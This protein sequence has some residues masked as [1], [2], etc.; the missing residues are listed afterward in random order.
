MKRVKR[1][2]AKCKKELLIAALRE[3]CPHGDPRFYELII[4]FCELHNDKNADYAS[5]QE[6]LGNFTRNGQIARM[7]GLI[8]P[9]H[10]ATKIAILYMQKQID[11]AYKLIGSGQKGGVESV[12][13]RLGDVTVYSIIA[14]IL[15]ERGL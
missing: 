7:Y 10:E 8:T 11:A 2:I 4:D 13:S 1:V 15:Y 3:V 6:P 12:A 9:G 14:R 5:K